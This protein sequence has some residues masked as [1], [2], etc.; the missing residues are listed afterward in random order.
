MLPFPKSWWSKK[1]R[2]HHGFDDSYEA[3]KLDIRDPLISLVRAYPNYSLVF[4]GHSMGGAIATIAAV[5]ALH[6]DGYLRHL[7]HPS[8][9]SIYTFGQPRTG[10]RAYVKLLNSMGLKQVLRVVNSTDPIPHV[11]ALIQGYTHHLKEVFINE[12]GESWF[13]DD[14]FRG[15]EDRN[16]A[17]LITPRYYNFSNHF[18][19]YKIGL[20]RHSLC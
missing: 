8:E 2:T 9:A 17:R 20:G 1:I 14:V 13:C 5:D 16:C 7:K 19:Y 4:T 12:E 3:I 18:Y 15:G 11:P 10:N 6:P